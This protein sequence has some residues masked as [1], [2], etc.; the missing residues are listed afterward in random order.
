MNLF[1]DPPRHAIRP[2]HLIVLTGM[3]EMAAP[4][5]RGLYEPPTARSGEI[6]EHD[7]II[8]NF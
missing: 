3:R 1:L 5:W 7:E 8:A 2:H 4:D 6:W